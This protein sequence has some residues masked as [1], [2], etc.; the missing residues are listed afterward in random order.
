MLVRVEQEYKSE[1][2]KYLWYNNLLFNLSRLQRYTFILKVQRKWEKS[3]R[4]SYQ[5]V[6]GGGWYHILARIRTEIQSHT[7]LYGATSPAAQP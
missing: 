4:K 7:S 3:F 2:F 1:V 5:E 6:L